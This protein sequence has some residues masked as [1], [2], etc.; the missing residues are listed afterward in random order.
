L[1]ETLFVTDT[2]MAAM[3]YFEV[4]SDMFNAVSICT[5][6]NYAL[7]VRVITLQSQLAS[8]YRMKESRR[9]S[10]LLHRCTN[11]WT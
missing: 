4:I 10:F 5:N 6:G 9:H 2:N 1:Y 8:P 11:C 3:R 7:Q